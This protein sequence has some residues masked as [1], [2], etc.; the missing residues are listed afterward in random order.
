MK[1]TFLLSLFS[2]FCFSTFG[3]FQNP[4]APIGEDRC[5]NAP[6]ID[7]CRLDGWASHTNPPGFDYNWNGDVP[8]AG[9]CNGRFTI[10]NNQWLKFVAVEDHLY[11]DV[12]VSGCSNSEGIQMAA[13]E[14]VDPNTGNCPGEQI[15][16]FGEAS[17]QNLS[18]IFEIDNLTPGEEYLLMIDGFAGDGCPFVL[19]ITSGIPPTLEVDA[20]PL[21]ICPGVPA[22]SALNA[23]IVNPAGDLNDLLFGWSTENGNIV[24]GAFTLNPI[25]DQPGDYTF[26]AFNLETCCGGFTTVTVE[27]TT[28]LPVAQASVIQ[29]I[30]CTS[31]TAT[32]SAAGSEVDNGF[33][34]FE[35]IWTFPNGNIAGTGFE[36]EGL[37]FSG[38]YILIVRN[39]STGCESQVTVVVDEDFAE[40]EI[41]I[42]EPAILTCADSTI[43]LL[44]NA[45]EGSTFEWSNENGFSS[46]EQAPSVTEPGDY[47]VIVTGPNG[48]ASEETI[49]VIDDLEEPLLQVQTLVLDCSNPSAPISIINDNEETTYT[50]DGV[51]FSTIDTA[52]IINEAGIYTL[53]ATNPNGCSNTFMVE[54]TEDMTPPDITIENDNILDCN[55]TEFEI[56]TV[57]NSI[58]T[59]YTWTGP[60]GFTEVESSPIIT[61][62]GTYMLT[63][64]DDKGCT[65]TTEITISDDVS[66]PDATLIVND[67]LTCDVESVVIESTS[68][69]TITAYEW[70][71]NLGEESSA[72]VSEAGNYTVTITGENGCTNIIDVDVSDNFQEPIP[73]AGPDAQLTCAQSETMLTAS[74]TSNIGGNL[75]YEWTLDGNTIGTGAEI[76]ISAVG[77]YQVIVTDE[78]NGCTAIDEVEVSSDDN[79]PEV[80]LEEVTTLDCNNQIV[81][82]SGINSSAG[83]EIVYEWL[84]ENQNTISS[85]PTIEVNEI[86]TYTFI[87]LNTDNGCV[88]QLPIQV[89]EN[90]NAPEPEVNNIEELNCL[91]TSFTA[92]ANDLNTNIDNVSYQ[93]FDI[94]TGSLI[95]QSSSLEIT[96]EG[97]Y[98]LIITNEENGCSSEIPFIVENNEDTPVADAGSPF[99]ITCTETTA[100]L[101]ASSS[102]GNNLSYQWLDAEGNLIAETASTNTSDEGEYT[103][104]VTDTQ[105]GCSSE[106][107]VIV[108]TNADFPE[109]VF[110]SP[111]EIN[112]TQTLSLL[113]ASGSSGTGNLTFAWFDVNQNLISNDEFIEV[114]VAGS[115]TLVLTDTDSDCT[116]EESILVTDNFLE[117]DADAGPAQIITCDISDVQLDGSGSSNG[118]NFIYEWFNSNNVLLGNSETVNVETPGEYIL[119]IT[120]NTNGCSSSSTVVVTPDENIPNLEVANDGIL[121]CLQNQVS[122]FSTLPDNP[123][124][125]YTWQNENGES[126]S[127]STSYTT[128]IPGVYILTAF[129]NTNGCSNSMSILVEDN[130][131]EPE[132]SAATPDIINCNT[133][134]VDLVALVN[135]PTQNIAYVWS[136]ATENNIGSEASLTVDAAGTYNL[137]ATNLESGCV[138]SI[139]VVVDSDFDILTPDAI[140][141]NI[142][143]CTLQ[144]AN[145]E[146][147][148]IDDEN[149]TYEWF[150]INNNSIGE[151]KDI[152]IV[153]EGTYEVVVTNSQNGCS[154]STIAVVESNIQA[155]PINIPSTDV[156]N[157]Q[158]LNVQLTGETDDNQDYEYLWLDASGTPLSTDISF[159]VFN[160]GEYQLFILDTS[161]GCESMA[162]VEVQQNIN[163]PQAIIDDLSPLGLSC[164][165]NAVLLDGSASTPIGNVQYQWF[166]ENGMLV[167][168]NATYEATNAGT[169]NLIITD[170]T[171]FCENSS[172]TIVTQ[173]DEIPVVDIAPPNML[174]CNVTSVILDA[175][176]SELGSEFEYIWTTPTGATSFDETNI[177]NPTTSTPGTYTLTIINTVTG[178]ENQFSIEV[179]SDFEEP[180]AQANVDG[181]LDCVTSEVQLNTDGSSNGNQFQKSW[182][183]DGVTLTNLDFVTV[184]NPGVYT[185]I[186]TDLNNGCTSESQVTVIENTERPTDVGLTSDDII[187]F[188]DNN[189]IIQINEIVG[190]TAP[191]TIELNGQTFTDLPS[192]DN[193]GPGN[194]PLLVTDAIGCTLETDVTIVEPP[195]VFVALGADI[196]INLGESTFLSASTNVD[197]ITWSS[198]GDLDCVEDCL[199]QEVMPLTTTTYEVLVMDENGCPAIDQIVVNIQFDRA[200]YIPNAFSPNAD[201]IN[202]FFRVFGNSSVLRVQNMLIA[203]KWGEIVYEEDDILLSDERKFW[204]GRHR[205]E[206]L[207]D[208]VLVYYVIVEYIDGRTDFFKGDVTLIR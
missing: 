203:N 20:E 108:D 87:V 202:D 140:V 1:Q 168:E 180:I 185:L 184:E 34:E 12:D 31:P 95:G 59:S 13:Y 100:S 153:E 54:V 165:Q 26:F 2:L 82:L 81:S 162:S 160:P 204:D 142:L 157:C 147:I 78:S 174:T 121:S 77:T 194:Y 191:Y 67:I 115:Y 110:N 88:S 187:C 28:D 139:E 60:N 32:V 72:S 103:L 159:S 97:N 181:V 61:E 47:Q 176:Q 148:G 156:L 51:S 117:P 200:V 90:F 155:P 198:E 92:E 93:W 132:L 39:V 66:P 170:L 179:P 75:S 16:C 163:S 164:T 49:T 80:V 146:A 122:L 76:S 116:I 64:M 183:I 22:I 189:G 104:I 105:S 171:T 70:S 138:N 112:C 186:V 19:D 36:L 62:P 134:E 195:Q 135:N 111:D 30:G 193:L 35:Y 106:S 182:I 25:I 125:T 5:A 3:Q 192:L 158:I 84:D 150:D 208:N 109:I 52:P 27:A 63:V 69:Q 83:P 55:L 37:T 145:I 119:V 91:I 43:S 123:N 124:Y 46:M 11:I 107:S 99:T 141:S 144:S 199:I 161:N 71:N 45:P 21:S 38:E 56:N 149:Y 143:N 53:V 131:D 126:L 41:S 42:G 73:N 175:S 68:N 127:S 129:D 9:W 197:D 102:Q 207:N 44:V 17:G 118:N 196:T 29:H 79:I 177:L 96:N 114:E 173:D 201:G 4:C 40:P 94:N 152:L 24:S 48:C 58:I 113:N 137:V 178:C 172:N 206:L 57:S 33:N 89:E 166:D 120:D 15:T 23:S 65:N 10:E 133:A 98:N 151:G 128:D 6:L 18:L 205:G 14:V 169:Y 167:S 188:G 154:S 101:D 85:S 190:G 50:L 136:S 7:A 86:G 8:R 74:G 130:F